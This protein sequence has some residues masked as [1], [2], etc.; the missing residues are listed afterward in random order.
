ML[1]SEFAET[2]RIPF[3][4]I[5]RSVLSGQVHFAVHALEQAA[6]KIGPFV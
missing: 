2:L 3:P 5:R 1:L 4:S 6:S